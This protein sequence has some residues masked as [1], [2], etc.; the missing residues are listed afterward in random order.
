[1][2]PASALLFLSSLFVP[3]SAAM[4][5][6]TVLRFDDPSA[7]FAPALGKQIDVRFSEAFAAVHLPKADYDSVVLS[8]LPA[9]K[10]CL[11][12]REQGLD[13]SDPKLADV[14]RPEGNDICVA[15]ADVAVRIAGP[16][17]DGPAMPFYNTD[18]KLCVWNWNT[19][20]DI[21][22]WS[23]DCLFESGRWNVVYDAAEDLY[24][25]RVDDGQPFPV[26]RQ[27][28]IDPDGGPESYLPDLKARGL[29]RDEADCVFAPSAA[30]EAPAN[31]S[32]WE[33]VPVGKVKEAF[34]A[35]PKDEVPEPPCGDL[36]FA[37]DYIGF[38]MVHKDHPDR[39]LYINL[40]QDGTMV[41]PFSI[42]LF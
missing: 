39:L 28:H 7:F 17:S 40:G 34:E 3:A 9:G 8:Q 19:G 15:R 20:K 13:A 1:M 33:V 36:G 24:G 30:Q 22:L 2:R 26:V 27:F 18:K 4:A 25:L 35:L 6:E 32:I 37:V 10:V 42:S 38:F 12:G 5:G 41:D 11:F 23:E 21:G 16:A 31:W 14:A 29:V